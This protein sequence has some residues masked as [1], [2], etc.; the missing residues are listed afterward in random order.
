[1]ACF[2]FAAL[3]ESCDPFADRQF[4]LGAA[5]LQ[6]PRFGWKTPRDISLFEETQTGIGTV[7][8]IT[9]EMAA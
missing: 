6:A 3:T 9:A 5:I 2:A 4:L 1:L 7:M 8:R